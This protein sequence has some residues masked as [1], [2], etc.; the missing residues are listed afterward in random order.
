MR[1]TNERDKG[2]AVGRE[3]QDVPERITGVDRA[4]DLVDVRAWPCVAA[5]EKVDV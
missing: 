2:R 5:S 3:F 1:L 4:G